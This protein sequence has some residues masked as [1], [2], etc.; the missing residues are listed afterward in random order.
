MPFRARVEPGP[1]TAERTRRAETAGRWQGESSA[2]YAVSDG[3]LRG[4]RRFADLGRRPTV[5]EKV[6][7][8]LPGM[9]RQSGQDVAQVDE[10]VVSMTLA[11]RHQAE[12]HGH[13]LTTVLTAGEQPV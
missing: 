7:Q 12:Q 5:G 3:I 1:N 4:C 6:G 13:R 10:R 2:R 11:A 9:V 8:P